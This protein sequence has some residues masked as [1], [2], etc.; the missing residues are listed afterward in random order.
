MAAV[1][2][3]AEA[4]LAKVAAAP[5]TM[6]PRLSV[7][8]LRLQGAEAAF[9]GYVRRDG[10]TVSFSGENA[11]ERR[12]RERLYGDAV[13]VYRTFQFVRVDGED[14]PASTVRVQHQASRFVDDAAA[15]AFL[16]DV[17]N[18]LESNS[19]FSDLALEAAPPALGD[20]AI[21]VRLHLRFPGIN[22]IRM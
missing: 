2:R 11:E 7:H 14:D 18:V 12:V 1:E 8:G 4:L 20:E 10:V 19:A 3:L 22:G 16:T 5:Q 9:D 6:T 13:A 15:A 17:L 21:A